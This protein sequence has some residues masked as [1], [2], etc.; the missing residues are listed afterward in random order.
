MT[1]LSNG[2]EVTDSNIDRTLDQEPQERSALTDGILEEKENL[3]L[4][5]EIA[6]KDDS[7]EL[8]YGIAD[9]P[10]W[11]LSFAL[12][13]QH[14]LTAFGSTLSVPLILAGPLCFGEDKVGLSELIATTFFTSGIITILQTCL[15]VRLPIIQGVTFAFLPPTMAILSLPRW[16]CPIPSAS[17]LL[18]DVNNTDYGLDNH[19]V[20]INGSQTNG[21]WHLRIRE[22]QGAICMASLFQIFIGCSGLMSVIMRYVGPLTVTPTIALIG[23]ALFEAA[24]DKAATQWWIAFMTLFLIALF[25]QYLKSISIPIPTFSMSRRCSFSYLPVFKLF[26]ILLAMLLS[27]FICHILTVTNILPTEKGEWG[28]HARTDAR[29]S[30]LHKSKWIR[31]PYPGQ[32]GLPT[33]SVGAVFGMLAGVLASMMES[34][35]DYYACARLSGAPVPPPSAFNR[36]IA[37]EGF[38]CLFAGLMGTGNGTTSYSENVGAIGITK[39]GSRCVVLAA[40][41][42]LILMGCV[43][44]VGALFVTIP[45]PVVGGMFFAM[46]GMIVAVGLSN[47]QFV[48]L[49]SSRNI[50]VI[51][52]SLFIGLAFPHWISNHRNA[53]QT[54]SEVFDQI[55]TVLCS[56]SMFVGGFIGFVLDL[57]LP[58]TLEERGITKWRQ[59]DKQ[60]ELHE[61]LKCEEENHS[62]D[63]KQS[64]RRIHPSV[65]DFPKGLHFLNRIPCAKCIPICPGSDTSDTLE[66]VS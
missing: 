28:F 35:A 19:S 37:V 22:L 48:D 53:I 20:V 66:R 6:T 29:D 46:F 17:G 12:G 23:L 33:V 43:G 7:E 30:V 10:P 26:P 32:W 61:E 55:V 9:N 65:Y 56:T 51:A 39:V 45:D 63:K 5:M 27:W 60:T 11:V 42:L 59:D 38:G 47:L 34:V 2:H 13:F 14:Y 18:S 58:G 50:F 8:L 4:Q 64:G 41:I 25:S 16:A 24:A 44:K 54:G 36:G 31:I 21:E 57:T 1:E 52:F 15:G 3:T 62:I 40:G 49:S